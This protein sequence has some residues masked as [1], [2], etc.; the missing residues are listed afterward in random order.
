MLAM[1]F[2]KPLICR[3]FRFPLRRASLLLLLSLAAGAAVAADQSS[4]FPAFREGGGSR[5]VNCPGRRVAHLV[6]ENGRFEPGS[7]RLIAVL[8]GDTP[9]PRPL[10]VRIAA[11]G[12]WSLEPEAAGLRLISIP[13]IDRPLLWESFP[14][15]GAEG[16]GAE[17]PPARTW[18]ET[19]ATR[20]R[21]SGRAADQ[22]VRLQL[23]RLSRACGTTV[24]T[25]PLLQAFGLEHLAAE[26]P[27]E[28]PVRCR[29]LAP[30]LAHRGA[31]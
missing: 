14:R 13:A 24:T 3:R 9:Q 23:Q 19:T 16:E 29:T 18:L 12:D 6:P 5:G 27:A 2:V 15:C 4:S 26:L 17:A 11:L 25:A 22:S 30:S 31:P 10:G 7:Q 1:E 20:E 21:S 8:E 28:L